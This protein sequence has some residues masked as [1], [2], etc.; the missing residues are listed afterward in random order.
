MR[1][2]LHVLF[3]FAVCSMWCI[4]LQVGA[5]EREE[6]TALP[7]HGGQSIPEPTLQKKFKEYLCERLGKT[8][9]D[10]MVSR[11]K[12]MGNRPLPPGD[13]HIRLFQ[14]DKERLKGY[15]RLTALIKVNEAVVNT[16]KLS[17]WAD[18]F[19]PVVCAHRP[20]K[21]GEIIRKDGVYLT[22]KN[23]SHLPPDVLKDMGKVVGQMVTHNIRENTCLKEWMLE[24]PPMVDRGDLVTIIAES[25]NLRVTVPG[26]V[27][28]RGCLGELV[29]VQ[30]TMSKKEIYAKVVNTSIVKVNF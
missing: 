25:G 22:R 16:V 5:G 15:V 17:G 6:T 8:E 19:E 1:K 13:T 27:L 30:N 3:V 14:K 29:K 4:P 7:H 2:A 20:L 21:K 28:E 11:F 10:V 23:I 18:V 24:R 26:K 9:S 12:V